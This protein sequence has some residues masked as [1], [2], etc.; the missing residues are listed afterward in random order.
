MERACTHCEGENGE[1]G[2]VPTIYIGRKR[3]VFNREDDN[4]DGKGWR[5]LCSCGSKGHWQ[6]QSPNVAY[7]SWLQHVVKDGK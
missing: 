5:W 1:L 3:H 6:G 2:D 4:Y 7:H